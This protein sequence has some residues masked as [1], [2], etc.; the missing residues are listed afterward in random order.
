MNRVRL[1]RKEAK[2]YRRRLSERGQSAV[3]F[4]VVVPILV[5][6]LVVIS[7][8]GR[9]FFVSISVNNAARAGAQYGSQFVTNA[10][11]SSG[12]VAAANLDGAN[13]SG[14]N[15]PTASECTCVNPPG[16]LTA[17]PGNYCS[18][19]TT[20]NYVEVDTSATYHTLLTYPG[21]PSS[22]NLTGKAV[23]QVQQ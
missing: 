23:M 2:A 6:L 21:I 9:I 22:Y 13:I 3:E 15:A 16:A 12:M 17:C 8:F 5:L 14:W 1:Q 10:K 20:A 18:H 7:D 11:D 4:A 19:T